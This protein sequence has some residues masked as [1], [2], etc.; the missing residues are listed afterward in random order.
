MSLQR[1]SFVILAVA[2]GGCVFAAVSRSNSDQPPPKAKVWPRI[3]THLDHHEV[4][5]GDKV[6]MRQFIG[7]DEDVPAWTYAHYAKQVGFYHH[8][9][10]RMAFPNSTSELGEV[11]L[12]QTVFGG[13]LPMP[14]PSSHPS[15]DYITRHRKGYEFE[16]SA[17]KPGVYLLYGEW[18]FRT[19]GHGE[20]TISGEPA[21]LYVRQPVDAGGKDIVD[22][23]LYSA[24]SL[25]DQERLEF[26]YEHSPQEWRDNTSPARSS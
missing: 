18:T 16:F 6:A 11:V 13:S 26:L 23:D 4:T 22:P 19:P 9:L 14:G 12:L 20:V 7:I 24:D 1:R 25:E 2:I 17:A 3:V 8:G 21:L 15:Y 5:V 10:K